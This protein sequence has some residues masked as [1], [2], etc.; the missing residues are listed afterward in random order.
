VKLTYSKMSIYTGIPS[1]S[2]EIFVL[3]GIRKKT[4]KVQC[5]SL[6]WVWLTIRKRISEEKLIFKKE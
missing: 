4:C 3:P 5:V 1:C 6:K 2:C